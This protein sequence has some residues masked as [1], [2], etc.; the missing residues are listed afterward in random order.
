VRSRAASAGAPRRPDFLIVGAPKCGTTALVRALRAHPEVFVARRK[1]LHFF[2]RDLGFRH[3]PRLDEPGYLSCFH[4]LPGVRRCGEASVWYLYSG[5]AASEIRAF[6]PAMRI[7]AM[8]RDPVEAMHALHAQLV[9][10]GLG[11]EDIA[12][13]AEAI[14]A[15]P[16]R[17][18]GQRIPPHTPLPEALFYHE[19]VRF[20]SQ[21]ERYLQ[22]FPREQIHVVVFEDLRSD[23][24]GTYGR[25]LRFLGVEPLGR[26]A[27]PAANRSRTVRSEAV[28]RW[29]GRVPRRWKQALPWSVRAGL[30][31]A[32][33]RVNLPE[34]PRSGLD[35]ALARRLRDA[36][37]PE[38]EKLE[39]LLDR[40]LSAWRG[41]P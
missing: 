6:N 25:A 15:E 20:G 4:A 16:E 9:C 32:I 10:N 33:R 28:R 31:R 37:R 3:R 5:R 23:P 19:V 7:I 40:D 35:P 26:L 8:I 39:R 36:C 24:S 11:D 29:I 1:D 21:L 41:G 27:L 18:S 12:D 30:R 14:A 38:V 2:G 17:R 34:R 13:F 22:A